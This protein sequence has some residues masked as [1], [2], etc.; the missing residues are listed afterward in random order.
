MVSFLFLPPPFHFSHA[1]LWCAEKARP[2]LRPLDDNPECW[3][4][5]QDSRSMPRIWKRMDRVCTWNRW[6][7]CREGVQDRIWWFCRVS[8]SAENGE[9]VMETGTEW[10]L[11]LGLFLVLFIG[12]WSLACPVY[13]IY[14]LIFCLFSAAPTAYR[15]SQ[16]KGWI[17]AVAAG[18]HHSSRQH[19]ILNPLCDA[20]DRTCVLV[21]ISQIR[22]HWTTRE[23]DLPSLNWQNCLLYL[24]IMSKKLNAFRSETGLLFLSVLSHILTYFP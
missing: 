9:E 14:F 4:A 3:A 11:S 20:R 6:Y 12:H 21:D 8:T 17:R 10:L 2:W 13:F 18:L 23:S 1:F 16:A 24:G 15:V 7:P 22:F 19:R 5:S